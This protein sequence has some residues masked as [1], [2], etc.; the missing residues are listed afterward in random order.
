MH[1]HPLLEKVK[2]ERSFPEAWDLHRL[3][4]VEKKRDAFFG[5]VIGSD[6][7]PILDPDG[8]PY[9]RLKV[10]FS[11]ESTRM[12]DSILISSEYRT[13]LKDIDRWFKG[14]FE[15]KI[16]TVFH[17]D[18]YVWN[19][20]ADLDGDDEDKDHGGERAEGQRSE[21]PKGQGVGNDSSTTPKPPLRQGV[22]VVGILGIGKSLFLIYILV[23]RLLLGL[24]T[25]IQIQEGKMTLW[26]AD[27]AFDIPI[28][29]DFKTV[30]SQTQKGALLPASTWYL[31]DSNAQ[32]LKPPEAIQCSHARIVQASSPKSARLDWMDK[33]Y[34]WCIVYMMKPPSL[35][36]VILM[37]LCQ[38]Y[39]EMAS[40]SDQAIA[41]FFDKYGPSVRSLFHYV[42]RPQAYES[43]LKRKINQINGETLA[44]LIEGM[45]DMLDPQGVSHLLFGVY[46]GVTRDDLFVTILTK[47]IYQLLKNVH[48][49]KW[50]M[51]VRR[52]YTLFKNNPQTRAAAGYILED[53]LHELLLHGGSWPVIELVRGRQGPRNI[54]YTSRDSLP[55]S[56]WLCVSHSTIL[57]DSKPHSTVVHPPLELRRYDSQSI[58]TMDLTETGYYQPYSAIQATYDSHVV[59]KPQKQVMVFRFTVAHKHDAKASG[60]KWLKQHYGNF[61][62]HY[63]VFADPSEDITIYIPTDF[64]PFLDSKLYVKITEKDLFPDVVGKGSEKRGASEDSENQEAK[65]VRGDD[66]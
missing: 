3:A 53:R 34:G 32:I 8:C 15:T 33:A 61:K 63:V 29:D 14:Y 25:C 47:H 41:E 59:N 56:K 48:A 24:E 64:D 18:D 37:K 40:T 28:D 60:L 42:L 6:G 50:D 46:P 7:T 11:L 21:N 26:C 19:R 2:Y 51:D 35:N 49:Q 58:E 44:S 4:Y 27:G 22:T 20:W 9:E 13:A 17:P 45:A 62:V 39:P 55:P 1:I 31:L 65:R 10:P 16:P 43:K 30:V 38:T 57:T 36:E 12:P 54:S 23:E 66:T 52:M 5:A